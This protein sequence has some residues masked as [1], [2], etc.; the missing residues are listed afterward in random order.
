MARAKRRG[1]PQM[2]QISQMTEEKGSGGGMRLGEGS[3]ETAGN[4]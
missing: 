4:Y 1:K 2:A 3:P